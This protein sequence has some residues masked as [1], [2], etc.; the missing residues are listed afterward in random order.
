MAGILGNGMS[1][2][3]ALAGGGID[4]TAL[5]QMLTMQSKDPFSKGLPGDGLLGPGGMSVP[6]MPQLSG[7]QQAQDNAQMVDPAAQMQTIPTDFADTQ[8]GLPNL[9]DNMG[10]FGFGQFA[11]KEVQPMGL[12]QQLIQHIM[13]LMQNQGGGNF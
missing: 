3:G 6:N 8:P 13:G 10:G 1:G 4:P 7:M 9:P 5:L 11:P 2:M 12:R